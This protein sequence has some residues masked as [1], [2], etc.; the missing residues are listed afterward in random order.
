[1][2]LT[3]R[4]T[5]LG[6]SIVLPLDYPYSCE[7]HPREPHPATHEYRCGRCDY[8][9]RFCDD[10]GAAL[11]RILHHPALCKGRSPEETLQ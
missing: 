1:M 4:P 3:R 8:W 7:V 11:L 10:D 9:F 2:D 5:R 6:A